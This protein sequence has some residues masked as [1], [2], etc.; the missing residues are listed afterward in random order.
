MKLTITIEVNDASPNIECCGENCNFIK[1]DKCRLFNN[2]QLEPYSQNM[3]DDYKEGTIVY[4]KTSEII[5]WKRCVEC[6]NFFY[7]FCDS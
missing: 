7:N 6:I 3:I 5:A 2:K 4:D 1:E